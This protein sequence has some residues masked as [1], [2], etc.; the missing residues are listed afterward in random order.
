MIGFSYIK[1]TAFKIKIAPFIF[2]LKVKMGAILDN[3]YYLISIFKDT[4]G[5]FTQKVKIL[6]PF[7]RTVA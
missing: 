3:S 7:L 4:G 1:R 6:T 5:V 2:I